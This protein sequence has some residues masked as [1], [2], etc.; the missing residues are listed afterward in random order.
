MK[1]VST[2][3]ERS[4]G[5]LSLLSSS[6]TLIC[7]ALP[8]LFVSLGMGAT[9]AVLTDSLPFLVDLTRNKGWIFGLSAALLAIN[10]WLLFHPGRQCPSDAQLAAACRHTTRL[11]LGVFYAALVLW[12]IGFFAAFLALPVML[13]LET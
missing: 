3:G 13:W 11:N 2:G 12:G 7:C 4:L 8:I 10:A 5:L 6:G 1:P 9:V